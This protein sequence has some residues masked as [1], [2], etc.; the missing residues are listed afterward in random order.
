MPVSLR[1][2]VSAEEGTQLQLVYF[3]LQDDF[4]EC[5]QATKKSLSQND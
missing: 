5:H 3:F 4:C 2:S 1:T